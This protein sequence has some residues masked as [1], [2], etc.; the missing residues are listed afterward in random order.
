MDNLEGEIIYE[1]IHEGALGQDIFSADLNCKD[2]FLLN[3]RQHRV[4]RASR[5]VF[6]PSFFNL[7]L[8]AFHLQ[9]SAFHLQLSAFFFRS[10]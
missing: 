8:S 2:S 10:R 4:R 7:L 6:A 1:E 3:I 5:A 9:L